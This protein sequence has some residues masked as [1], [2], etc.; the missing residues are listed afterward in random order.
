[1]RT[2]T[3]VRRMITVKGDAWFDS[4]ATTQGQAIG[5]FPIPLAHDIP[6]RS[7]VESYHEPTFAYVSKLRHQIKTLTFL[8]VGH[9]PLK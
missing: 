1:M 4:N 6:L 7:R 8:G 3:L 5:L 9:F 2:R